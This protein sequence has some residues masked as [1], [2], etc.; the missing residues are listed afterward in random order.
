[1]D[2][3][4]VGS[5]VDANETNAY[6]AVSIA[7]NKM[8]NG[9]LYGLDTRCNIRKV[10]SV[11]PV[12]MFRKCGDKMFVKSN[13]DKINDDI[14][15]KKIGFVNIPIM[16]QICVFFSLL[17]NII[18]ECSRKEET[19]LMTYNTL[20]Y[21]ALPC[22]VV[23]K[24]FGIK[25]VGI[26]ADLPIIKKK[27]ILKRVEDLIEI[28]LIKRFSIL[29]P[30]TKYIAEDFAP[31]VP[32]IVVEAGQNEQLLSLNDK[33]SK[34]NFDIVFSG[35]LNSLSGIELAISA[36]RLI[37]QNNVFLHIYGR[38]ELEDYVVRAVKENEN[39][40]FHGFVN[41]EEMMKIQQDAN[42][43]ICPRLL[44]SFTTKYTFPSKVLEYMMSGKPVICNDLPGIPSEYH[45]YINIPKEATDE[46]WAEMLIK[47]KNNYQEYLSKA[48][49]GFGY[50][51]KF[52]NWQYQG[53]KI[54]NFL[55]E[56]S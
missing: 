2:I 38:G 40:I 31:S 29:I 45:E 24:L 50:A 53:E 51:N 16:K 48:R 21:T 4:Y 17:I 11:P 8:Q 33:K 46:A 43:L 34:E 5:C 7:G 19:L 22:I 28:D 30:L 54:Y 12:K 9:I 52:K 44:D 26:I 27:N 37:K 39:I 20:S 13:I 1:M 25:T 6:N 47:I 42:I 3:V 23:G 55:K 35:T 49:K 15:I 18:R 41:N 32:Y 36:M 10:I 14:D 56:N